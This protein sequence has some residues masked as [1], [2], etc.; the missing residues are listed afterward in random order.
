MLERNRWVELED[1][2]VFDLYFTL[3]TSHNSYLFL[4]FKLSYVLTSCM[5]VLSNKTVISLRKNGSPVF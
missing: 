2:P 3:P 1:F 4:C 5:A